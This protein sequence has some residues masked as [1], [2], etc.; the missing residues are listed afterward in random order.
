[1]KILTI[2]F[3]DGIVFASWLFL[4]SVGLTFIYGVLRILNVAHGS[5]YALGGY[6]GAS[7]VLY[8]LQTGATPYLTYFVLLGAALFIG[9][10]AGSLIETIFLRRVYH[11]EEEVQLLLT[12]S[13]FLIL[14][15]VIKLVWG[16]SPY[17]ADKPYA[18][19]G[20]M[21]LGGII[22]A[23]YVF[24]LPGI[25]LASGAIIWGIINRTRFGKIIISVITDREICTSLGVNVPRVRTFAFII[26]AILATLGGAFTAPMTALVPGI[27]VE[28][29]VLAF[30]VVA[31]GGMGSVGGAV[32]G[33]LLVGLA[34]AAA[35]HLFPELDL[36]TIY[37]VMSLVL[38]FRPQGLFGEVEVRRI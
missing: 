35:I 1:L 7:M 14:E 13:L 8:Y 20:Q 31:I 23:Q 9:I 26:G 24:L 38:L 12:F 34:R 21:R 2:I 4:V 16:V 30:A 32:L 10:V 33:S 27:G 6:M 28:V 19:L 36:F 5:L 29:I 15:D 17:F 3:V 11:R 37:L 18:L 22:Y 25:A